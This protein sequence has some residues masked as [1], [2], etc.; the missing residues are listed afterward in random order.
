ML[1]DPPT[2]TALIMFVGAVD[3]PVAILIFPGS[4]KGL[5]PPEIPTI[6]KQAPYSVGAIVVLATC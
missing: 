2:D 4:I 3:H 6:H 5:T 1:F